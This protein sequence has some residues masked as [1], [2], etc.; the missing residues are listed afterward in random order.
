[1]KNEFD[2]NCS[3]CGNGIENVFCSN[4]GQRSNLVRITFKEIGVDFLSTVFN[5]DAPF[6]KTY[7]RLFRNPGKL[8]REVIGGRRKVYYAPIK[9][10]ILSLFVSLL[11]SSVIGYDPMENQQS[12][13]EDYGLNKPDSTEVKIGHF[14][15][16]NINYFI[17]L[18]PFIIAIISKMFFWKPT[19]N[20]A[21]R[22]VLGFYVSGQYLMISVVFV[23]LT[24]LSPN[25]ILISY[26]FL[27]LYVIYSFASLFNE[28]NKIWTI[29]K[30][31]FAAS[32]TIIIYFGSASSIAYFIIKYFDIT[33]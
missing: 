13:N 5:L 17:L 26:P 33:I 28:G 27:T 1:M 3:N 30:A 23:M 6:P 15:H 14:I 24:S 19:Y 12:T 20:L 4:C 8:V 32:I 25:A 16:Q 21:E 22:T 11:I 18:L 31:T 9:Y 7:V 29:V 2:E 10:L